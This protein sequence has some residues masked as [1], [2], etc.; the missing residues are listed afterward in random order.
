MIERLKANDY[1]TYL[2]SG[3]FLI[4]CG[5]SKDGQR[6]IPVGINFPKIMEVSDV[7][8]QKHNHKPQTKSQKVKLEHKGLYGFVERNGKKCLML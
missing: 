5:V 7:V 3:E 4:V 8:V 2:P 6:F 1:V